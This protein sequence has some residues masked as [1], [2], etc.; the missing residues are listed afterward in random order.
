MESKEL[1]EVFRQRYLQALAEPVSYDGGKTYRPKSSKVE[2][3]KKIP[4]CEP[5]AN[6][7]EKKVW[8]WSDL[9][10]G[11]K[12]II[13]F[14]NR[15]YPDVTTMNEHLILNFAEK[16]HPDDISIWVGDVSFMSDIYTNLALAR[17]PG[18]KIL[19]VGNH[20]FDRKD[21][22]ELNFDEVHIVY[23]VSIDGVDLIFTHYP[24]DHIPEP[25]INIHGHEHVAKRTA[26][27]TVHINVNCEFHDY[28]PIEL[29]DIIQW[30]KTRVTS[31]ERKDW[32]GEPLEQV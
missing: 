21:L 17:C 29:T 12:N 24:M 23:P 11:H 31:A 2:Q 25:W 32:T 9:H 20:D 19:V 16:V 15:P 27:D 18:Y 10:F 5:I 8:V 30:A 7:A 22:K 4:P 1:F 6:L 13:R 28:R 14:S 26:S 3:W